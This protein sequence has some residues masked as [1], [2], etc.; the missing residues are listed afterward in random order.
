M[1]GSAGREEEEGE[2]GGRQVREE[3]KWAVSDGS[4]GKTK[5]KKKKKGLS[6]QTDEGKNKRRLVEAE[7]A[8][9]S[10]AYTKLSSMRRRSDVLS[11]DSLK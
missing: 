10:R 11:K 2:E 6:T 9:L 7:R 3:E 8:D 5:K 4:K 1:R